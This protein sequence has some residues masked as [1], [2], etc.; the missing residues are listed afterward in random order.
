MRQV[1]ALHR[2][3]A[4]DVAYYNVAVLSFKASIYD[5]YISVMDACIYHTVTFYPAV[6]G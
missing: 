4:I 6:E 3:L 1:K 2:E 5:S